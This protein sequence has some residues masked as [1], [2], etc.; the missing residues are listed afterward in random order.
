MDI[1]TKPTPEQLEEFNEIS[2]LFDDEP[3][4]GDFF[5]LDNYLKRTDVP[6]RLLEMAGS[7]SEIRFL[8]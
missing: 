2:K 1:F 3:T 5:V 7:L 4:E 8:S 6:P